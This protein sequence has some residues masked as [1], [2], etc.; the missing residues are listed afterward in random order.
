MTTIKVRSE[1]RDRLAKL[2]TE[3]NLSMVAMFDE[4]V[5]QLERE[6]FFD[7]MRVDLERLREDDPEEWAAY[8]AESK[9]WEDATIAD[10]LVPERGYDVPERGYGAGE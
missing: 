9:E 8:R 2:A 6:A 5:A 3:R 4:L 10:G 1:S 7:R